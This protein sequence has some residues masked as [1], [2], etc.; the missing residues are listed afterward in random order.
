MIKQDIPL[1][2]LDLEGNSTFN[3]VDY[4]YMFRREVKNNNIVIP[5]KAPF[6]QKSVKMYDKSGKPLV[7]GTDYEFYGIMGKLTQFTGKPV[8]LFI[9]ILKDEILEW[10][11][12][13]QVVGNFNK[14]TNEILNMLHSIYEDDRYVIYENI[15]NKPLWFVPEIHQHSLTYDIYAFTDLAR[16]LK[17]IAELQATMDSAADF[18]VSTL[19]DHLDTYITGY[20]KVLLGLIN[21]HIANK[22]DAH[23]TDKTKIGLGL[24]D[25]IRVAD[26]EETL[27]GM[28]DDL[29]LTPYNAMRAVQAA[30]SRNERLYPSGNLPIL[31]YGSDTFIPPT[32]AGSFEG[33]GGLGRQHGA[34][35][36]TD[37]TLLILQHR[38]NGKIRGLYFVRATNW[39]SQDPDYE[40]TAYQYVHPT[41]T[42]AGA[43]LDTI[44]NGSNRYIMVV[45][46]SVK[47]I[48]YW[49][50]TR[51]TF[52][53]DRHILHRITG[54]WVTED[55]GHQGGSWIGRATSKACVMADASYKDAWC[56]YQTYDIVEFT[57]RRNT[58]HD[59]EWYQQRGCNFGTCGYSFHVFKSLSS[60]GVRAKVDFNHP[61]F[62]NYND[63]YF[64][65]WWPEYGDTSIEN[66]GIVSMFAKYSK[67]VR[68]VWFH[69]T[70]HAHWVKG[71]EDGVWAFRS[72]SS[73]GESQPGG[74]AGYHC[75]FRGVMKLSSSGNDIT[76]KI[77]PTEGSERLFEIDP[78][79]RGPGK[80]EWSEFDKWCLQTGFPDGCNLV[81][82]AQISD[83]MVVY[84]DGIANATFPSPYS[85]RQ[86]GWLTSFDNMKLPQNER[87]MYNNGGYRVF[88]ELNP[89]GLS[90]GFVGNYS[91]PMDTDNP[92]SGCI[93][94]KQLINRKPEWVC[95]KADI[96]NADFSYK[97]P[98]A[99]SNY[100]G[101]VYEHYPY[102]SEVRKTNLGQQIHFNN[103]AKPVGSPAPSGN[104]AYAK[105]ML[106]AA[107]S[108]FLLGVG[109]G[110][111]GFSG[112]G[113]LSWQTRTKIVNNVVVFTP[114]IVVDLNNLVKNKLI[115]LFGPAG[116]N[117]QQ[118]SGTWHCSRI[119]DPD[120]NIKEVFS[121]YKVV[122]NHC[123]CAHV[124]GKISF[125]G[126]PTT[127]N[128][129][130]KYPDAN[131]T[132]S[133]QV[134]TF[135][136]DDK[137][138]DD[139]QQRNLWYNDEGAAAIY[140]GASTSMPW[141]ARDGNGNPTDKSSYTLNIRFSSS[142]MA[143]YGDARVNSAIRVSHPGGQIT[144]VFQLPGTYWSIVESM[145]HM[146]YY[147]MIYTREGLYTFETAG[148][149]GQTLNQGMEPYFG[150]EGWQFT[151][152]NAVGA[153]NI[154]TPAY[155]IYFQKMTNILLAGKMYSIPATYIDILDQ[156]PNPANKTFY[157]YLYY[158]SG[159]A[160]YVVSDTVRPESA[161]QSL[162]ATVIAGPTQID[163]IIPYN[164]FSI[165]GASISTNR[166]GS[167]IL[168][169]TGSVFDVG[170]TSAILR[171]GDFIPE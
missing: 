171:D 18:M 153:T 59:A 23:G 47:N 162:I 121:V 25:D 165:D 64:T 136:T 169:S 88:D 77:T 67:P 104:N 103:L 54:P 115:S 8:G 123:T 1:Y 122:N 27:E 5:P 68:V 102:L 92:A 86:Y 89:L 53:P 133:S 106:G 51:G 79:D 126:T 100:G 21:S 61:V 113:L 43:Q 110:G 96:Y 45:G 118:L 138:L 37:G 34:I 168:G 20:K 14:I 4:E 159:L 82:Y 142:Y 125:A 35:V 99:S 26:L 30:A 85:V 19:Q 170:D 139:N 152:P 74:W 11:I 15:E 31:R 52:N 137:G 119:T 81:G 98:T 111:N 117:Q 120:G 38:N 33:L 10:Y 70:I 87:F 129:Y 76:I 93:M 12:D 62:G 155:T 151:G 39:R 135:V 75:P 36:E 55:I 161:T 42:A 56:I 66:Y 17:R 22:K 108:T 166:Q 65:P 128:G 101:K 28:R 130:T 109:P 156:D 158:S 46:D 84:S 57:K 94:T 16:E 149:G 73:T 95:R 90:A 157:V 150:I 24:V 49:C 131:F 164:R 167:T 143:S 6:Y 114:E 132:P 78:Y 3:K 97:K 7:E 141:K 148:N 154:I 91:F 9:R 144:N 40:F 107:C 163:R 160:K 140:Q 60:T 2:K 83:D 29:T 124:I 145:D 116:F 32:I 146:P 105:A 69:R 63:R 58:G 72:Q 80:L 134:F 48:W 127:V 71:E 44:I 41:A 112:D 147:G 13:Y 50:E